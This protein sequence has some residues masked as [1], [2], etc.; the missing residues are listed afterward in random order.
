MHS[1]APDK[2][3]G[4]RAALVTGGSRGI[5]AAVAL[6]LA[7]D[8]ADVALTYEANAERARDVAA[9]I[10]ELGGRAWTVRTSLDDADS[11]RAAADGAAET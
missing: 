4:G 3:L 9:R 11:V 6:R 5:G 7:A 10:E 2:P 8:G 1:S